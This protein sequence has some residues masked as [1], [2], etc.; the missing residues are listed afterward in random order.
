MSRAFVSQSL[1]TTALCLFAAVILAASLISSNRSTSAANQRFSTLQFYVGREVLPDHPLYV[2]LMARD[3]V[4]LWLAN[5]EKAPRLRLRYAEKRFRVARALA[6]QNKNT[7]AISTL[8]KSQIYVLDAV[9]QLKSDS[10]SPSEENELR[11][12]LDHS[13]YRLRLFDEQYP[14]LDTS[15]LESLRAETASLLASLD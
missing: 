15:M 2:L 10:L 11:A 4:Q 9:R 14:E 7:L 5:D 13:L 6:A 3:R 12:A 8:S 1:S